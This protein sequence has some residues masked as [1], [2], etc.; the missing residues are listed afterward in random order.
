MA[1]KLVVTRRH[2]LAATAALPMWASACSPLAAD[3]SGSFA[4]RKL[5]FIL[6]RGAADG[7]SLVAPVGDPSFISARGR[8][9]EEEGRHRLNDLF[10]LH[11]AL[12][13]V[14]EM[15]SQREAMVFHA[16]GL[17]NPTRSHFDAQNLLETGGRAP[18]SAETGVL[19][20][21]LRIGND[22]RSGLA[23]APAIPPALRGM[24]RVSSYA[25]DNRAGVN[26]DF[27]ARVASLYDTN[28]PV[29]ER[30]W[31]EGVETRK[32]GLAA[33][34]NIS[35]EMNKVGALAAR[36]LRG[37]D[38]FGVV[39][40]ESTGWDTH[41]NQFG[42]LMRQTRDLDGILGG[43]KT[44][45]G[46]A[47]SDTLVIVASEFGRT[48]ATNGNG[49]TDH[50]S[51]GVLLALGGSLPD[52]GVRTDW[53]GLGRG[54]LFENRDLRTTVPVESVIATMAGQHFGI[55]PQQAAKTLYPD[56]AGLKPVI[57]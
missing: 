9:A 30:V 31:S 20:R 44:G 53:P 3:A 15:A 11:P 25:P 29:L 45:L 49:G 33:A 17:S 56:L 18:Y 13:T 43:L 2:V 16:V 39:M 35:E 8:L 7:L 54:N 4:N 38:G 27:Y 10:A 50:G 36:F 1:L 12:G 28:D 26:A 34:G 24:G 21:M 40:I 55:D 57:L 46:S 42:R 51:A 47:W 37:E 6:L 41:S 19:N 52:P 23:L 48:V 5:V 22:E 14:A 32:A